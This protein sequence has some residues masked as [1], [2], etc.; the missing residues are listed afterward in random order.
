MEMY[1]FVYWDKNNL[2]KENVIVSQEEENTK[3][4]NT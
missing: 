3:A 2:V 1:F 4:K